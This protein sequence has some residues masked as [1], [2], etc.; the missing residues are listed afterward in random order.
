[1]ATTWEFPPYTTTIHR[2]VYPAI[3]P[4]NSANSAAEKVVLITSGGVGLGKYIA[5]AY[6]KAGARAIAILGR[7]ESFLH[8]A[9][10]ELEKA[11]DAKVLTFAVDVLDE[12]G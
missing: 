6:N 8:E 11:G 4:T 9:A 10:A 5:E 12:A 1:M 3:D 7:R 2:S